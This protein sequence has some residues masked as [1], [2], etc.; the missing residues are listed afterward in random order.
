VKQEVVT[1]GIYLLG[2]GAGMFG[3]FCPSLYDV[4]SPAFSADADT[5]DLQLR[6]LRHG[7]VYSALVILTIGVALSLV[8][9]SVLPFGVATFIV[10]AYL[11]A[12]EYQ[13]N[14]EG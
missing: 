8:H 2:F 3:A 1:S 7:E 9:K 11:V 10:A 5:R 13:L 12:Y 4:S 14:W 6:R